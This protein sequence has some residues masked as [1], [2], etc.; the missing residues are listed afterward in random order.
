MTTPPARERPS[1][2]DGTQLV[3]HVAL[4]HGTWTTAD[5]YEH[6]YG[7]RLHDGAKPWPHFRDAAS[8]RWWSLSS[9]GKFRVEAL[10]WMIDLDQLAYKPLDEARAFLQGV[11]AELAERAARFGGVAAPELD[12]ERALVEMGRVREMLKVRE[13]RVTVVVAAP[14]GSAYEVDAWWRALELVGLRHGDGDLFWR[15]DDADDEGEEGPRELF[16]AEPHSVRGYFHAGDRGRPT[17]FP[18]VA[19]HF[20][21]RDVADPVALLRAMA[22]VAQRLASRLG[23]RLLDEEGRAFDLA[24]VEARTVEAM[25]R[26]RAL[27][28]GG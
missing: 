15:Y 17:R 26:L 9:P 14:P 16:C 3:V 20:R 2:Y 7:V 18:D 8:G 12:V 5:L 11:F 6:V 21:A 19:L 23:A 10:A 13:H 4:P 1:S 22:D 25:A 24:G 28:G 27:R